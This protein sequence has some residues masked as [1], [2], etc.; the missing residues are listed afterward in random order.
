MQRKARW[1]SGVLLMALVA[2]VMS[3]CKK[4]KDASLTQSGGG[5]SSQ[6]VVTLK[7]AAS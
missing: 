7:G 6:S 2:A 5:V 1:F 4:K 3:G